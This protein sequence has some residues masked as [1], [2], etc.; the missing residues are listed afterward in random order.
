MIVIPE[1]VQEE[2]YKNHIEERVKEGTRVADAN[3]LKVEQE[4]IN[5]RQDVDVLM[6]ATKGDGN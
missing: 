5:E 6:V 1:E 3:G 2:I 4:G